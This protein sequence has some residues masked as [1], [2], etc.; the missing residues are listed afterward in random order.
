MTKDR[1]SSVRMKWEKFAKL[2]IDVTDLA[3][4]IKAYKKV[5][6]NCKKKDAAIASSYKLLE[7][8]EVKAIIDNGRR[9]KES[10]LR[11]A[12]RNEQIKLAQQRIAHE[13]ELDAV[14][15]DIVMRRQT[16]KKQ[17][18][19]F[20]PDKKAFEMIVIE[21]LPSESDQVQAAREL[22]KR[23]GSYAVTTVKHEGGD[24]FLNFFAMLAKPDNP[25]I[26]NGI[27]GSSESKI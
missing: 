24:S 9:E 8:A 20:N 5:Y 26:S 12:I 13:L 11:E 4:Q 19:M 14:M 21:E 15:S 10:M 18:P 25:N 22:Y 3:G 17:Q 2:M 1:P 7:K 16:R 23:K 27:P 6:P